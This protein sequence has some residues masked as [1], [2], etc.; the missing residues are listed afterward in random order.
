MEA[1]TEV[2][3]A[4]RVDGMPVAQGSMTSIV[5]GRWNAARTWFNAYLRKDGMPIVET[6]ASNDKALK[7]WRKQVTSEAKVAWGGEP[8]IEET[9]VFVSVEFRFP[10][11][12]SDLR[13]NGTP[14]A[15]APFYKRSAPDVDK[16]Q[17]AVFDALTDAQVWR[18][19]S[20]VVDVHARKV[21]ADQPGVTVW[22]GVP[23]PIEEEAQLWEQ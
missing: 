10:R 21:Y 13:S 5:K 23:K 6:V 3:L 15:S 2:R 20:L 22:V 4:L 19:D 12:S 11:R 17:R 1:T 14:K 7:P 9:D 18:D 16:L 8:W